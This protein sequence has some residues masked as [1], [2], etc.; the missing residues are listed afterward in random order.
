MRAS[1]ILI[2][3]EDPFFSSLLQA[4]LEKKGGYEVRTERNPDKGLQTAHSL[5]PDIILC[6]L[7]MLMTGDRNV[8]S[9][10]QED[11]SLTSTKIMTI[12]SPDSERRAENQGIETG[13]LTRLSKSTPLDQWFPHVESELSLAS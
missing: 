9:R 12:S 8:I 2:I 5:H 10:V 13:N 7:M 11:K 3:D 1:R 6:D 4:I